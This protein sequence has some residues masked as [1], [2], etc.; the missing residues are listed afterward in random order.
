MSAIDTKQ[1]AVP[2]WHYLDIKGRMLHI[3]DIMTPWLRLTAERCLSDDGEIPNGAINTTDVFDVQMG[4]HKD[5]PK[6]R[7]SESGKI[8]YD[9]TEILKDTFVLEDGSYMGPKITEL[10]YYED[11]HG[12]KYIGGSIRSR[13]GRMRSGEMTFRLDWS[14]EMDLDCEITLT[15]SWGVDKIDRLNMRFHNKPD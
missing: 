7:E 11:I 8:L 2:R 1:A 13:H 15:L 10:G 5:G 3:Q 6:S 14:R 12:V 4:F 9:V